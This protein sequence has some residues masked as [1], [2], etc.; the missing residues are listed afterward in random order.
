MA[1]SSSSVS[2]RKRTAEGD[3]PI[4][5]DANTDLT[6]AITEK[7]SLSP[8]AFRDAIRGTGSLD[9]FE[10]LARQL[11]PDATSAHSRLQVLTLVASEAASLAC[12]LPPSEVDFNVGLNER[13]MQTR[14]DNGAHIYDPLPAWRGIARGARAAMEETAKAAASP[15]EGEAIRAAFA[16]DIQQQLAREQQAVRQ[17]RDL[18][19][20]KARVLFSGVSGDDGLHICMCAGLTRGVSALTIRLHTGFPLEFQPAEI[21]AYW[22]EG[23]RLL[24]GP[25]LARC[26]RA[27]L[28]SGLSVRECA[29]MCNSHSHERDW[30]HIPRAR[31]LTYQWFSSRDAYGASSYPYTRVDV[32]Q[33][34]VAALSALW[35]QELCNHADASNATVL[36]QGVHTQD[37][38][39]LYDHAIQSISRMLAPDALLPAHWRQTSHA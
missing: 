23:M 18:V 12:V 7:W 6:D 11:H 19:A 38:R 36:L 28:V 26:G 32:T 16:L 4:L 27:M 33:P 17:R 10:E 14:I 13:Y 20:A 3:R 8:V 15:A 30:D 2:K 31:S 35:D 39:P 37:G 25:T 29:A 21:Y 34:H 24:F 22:I 9:E 1:S 5:F